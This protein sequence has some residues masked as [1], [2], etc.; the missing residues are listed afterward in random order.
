MAPTE[1]RNDVFQHDKV[2]ESIAKSLLHRPS[3]PY[4]LSNLC[5]IP[6]KLA[7]AGVQLVQMWTLHVLSAAVAHPRT[8]GI[9]LA[10]STAAM[11]AA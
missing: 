6:G 4:S 8:V 2:I 10:A 7:T 9:S 3:N 5:R 1:Q 11:R